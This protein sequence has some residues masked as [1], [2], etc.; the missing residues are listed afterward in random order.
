M[1]KF[2]TY[3]TRFRTGTATIRCLATL[4]AAAFIVL[5]SV[6]SA[7]ARLKVWRLTN[8][9]K[10]GELTVSVNKSETIKFDKDV[11]EAVVGSSDVVDVIH[12]RLRSASS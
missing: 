5:A 1:L 12:A 3:G 10:V 7:A 8:V 11:A 9:E 2:G 6:P 4:L